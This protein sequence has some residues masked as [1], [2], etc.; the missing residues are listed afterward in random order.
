MVRTAAAPILR[1]ES[2]LT[3]HFEEMRNYQFEV[4]YDGS[5][6]ERPAD[7]AALRRAKVAGI[8]S[9][10][11][12]DS[13]R[14]EP[15]VPMRRNG[16]A[17]IGR[18]A[19]QVDDAPRSSDLDAYFRNLDNTELLSRDE[20]LA[21]AKRIDETQRALLISLFRIPRIVER[22]SAWGPR[23]RSDHHTSPNLSLTRVCAPAASGLQFFLV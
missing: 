1:A 15:G 4:E 6:V 3:R 22:V 23:T 17:A 11:E 18:I 21:L 5:S 16:A 13:D 19:N 10:H 12:L 8:D 20:E 14:L 2:D 9:G 7:V